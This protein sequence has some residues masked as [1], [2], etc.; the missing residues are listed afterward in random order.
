MNKQAWE[1]LH[2]DG[3]DV[4]RRLSAQL[5]S[6][7]LAY[8]RALA[9]APLSSPIRQMAPLV[10]YAA[11]TL[12]G[13]IGAW[14][15]S[16]AYGVNAA[17]RSLFE[18]L[19]IAKTVGSDHRKAELFWKFAAVSDLL[20]TYQDQGVDRAKRDEAADA[21]E[22]EFPAWCFY[23]DQKRRFHTKWC[24]NSMS[25]RDSARAVGEEPFYDTFYRDASA[26]VHPTS[27]LGIYASQSIP[28]VAHFM[29]VRAILAGLFALLIV[30]TLFETF[31]VEYEGSIDAIQE[32]LDLLAQR[33]EMLLLSERQAA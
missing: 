25:I 21:I 31:D 16:S 28:D 2:R 20:D 30:A 23:K 7:V 13:V 11:D 27:R 24:A 19:L 9:M 14:K 22:R 26:Y 17:A 10:G 5:F 8:D 29:T 1:K 12:R 33:S 32:E 15:E 6:I 3:E 4:L 18:G